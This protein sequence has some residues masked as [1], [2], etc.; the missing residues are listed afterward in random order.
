MPLPLASH[1]LYFLRKV[2]IASSGVGITFSI[3][4]VLANIGSYYNSYGSWIVVLILLSFSVTLCAVDVCQYAHEKKR[5]E[6]DGED[7][8]P[9]WPSKKLMAADFI[10]VV[11]L[12][13]DYFCVVNEITYRLNCIAPFSWY[14][15]LT[16]LVSGYV[17][18]F[19]SDGLHCLHWRSAFYM[20]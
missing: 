13:Y 4:S 9:H 17:A 3:L 8:D 19:H 12:V 20:V 5:R 15:N 10:L 6:R 11:V 7:G 16:T 14:A 2:T 18:S 1:P